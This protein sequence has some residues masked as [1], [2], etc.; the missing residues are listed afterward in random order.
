MKLDVNLTSNNYHVILEKGLLSHINDYYNFE[1][2]KVLIVTDDGV[3]SSYSDLLLKQIDNS[4]LLVLPQGEKTKSLEGFSKVH[5]VLLNNNF[6][7]NDIIVALGGGVIG[8]LSA[9]CASTYKRGIKF[10]NIPTTTLSQIDSSVGG[11][12]AINFEGTKNI[13]GTFYQPEIVLIDFEVLQS[14][15]KRHLYNGLVEALKMGLILDEKLYDIFKMENYLA[16]LEEIIAR[17]IQRKIEVVQAD[18]KESYYRMILN[19]GHTLAH[20]FE[21]IYSLEG[22]Y[23]GEAV[24]NGMLYM[25]DNDNLKEEVKNIIS[26]MN[27]DIINEFDIGQVFDYLQKD[28]KVENDGVNIVLVNEVGKGEITKVFFD[29]IKKRIVGE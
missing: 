8:D 25:I 6:S 20:A 9:F 23:H 5:Q 1:N 18:E 15:S 2:K 21:S 19:F 4:I 26:K 27:I 22:I 28:K 11:K 16:H 12:T 14:L 24:A 3:P 17:S 13:I 7:R 29:D 10:I